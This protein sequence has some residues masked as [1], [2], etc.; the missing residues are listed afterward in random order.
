MKLSYYG[1]N[2]GRLLKRAVL[3]ACYQSIATLLCGIADLLTRSLQYIL[4][5]FATFLR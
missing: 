1:Y 4:L 3:Y 5:F 2:L